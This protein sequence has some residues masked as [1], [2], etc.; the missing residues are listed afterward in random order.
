MYIHMSFKSHESYV[1]VWPLLSGVL[2]VEL[3]VYLDHRINIIHDYIDYK[4]T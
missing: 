4:S 2:C 1:V 3:V